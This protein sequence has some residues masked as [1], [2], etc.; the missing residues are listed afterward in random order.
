M[1]CLTVPSNLQLDPLIQL[2]FT[3]KGHRSISREPCAAE[4][5]CIP[6]KTGDD[7]ARVRLSCPLQAS[8]V[9][10]AVK[11]VVRPRCVCPNR[12]FRCRYTAMRPHLR[13]EKTEL[14]WKSVVYVRC[15]TPGPP[16]RLT[17]H[18]TSS[19]ESGWEST[20]IR[21]IYISCSLL[22]MQIYLLYREQTLQDSNSILHVAQFQD[23][24]SLL[25]GFTH[26]K[27]LHNITSSSLVLPLVHHSYT[28]QQCLPAH[29]NSPAT[30]SGLVSPHNFPPPLSLTVPALRPSS[31]RLL[32]RHRQGPLPTDSLQ[33]APPP[34]RDSQKPRGPRLPPFGPPAHPQAG[35][36]RHFSGVGRRRRGRCPVPLRPPRRRGQQRRV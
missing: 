9:R 27:S 11:E 30:P 10:A 21:Y 4:S 5:W 17:R 13:R 12:W 6:A 25:L 34:R 14:G 23:N 16:F 20:H 22:M 26:T 15:A 2:E 1:H 35:P 31:H 24:S 3:R 36:R 33:A 18:R 8:V 32:L 7:Q 28:Q 29:T 19:Q